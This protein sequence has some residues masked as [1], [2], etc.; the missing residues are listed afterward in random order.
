MTKIAVVTDST[1]YI[2]GELSNGF[3]IHTVP[4]QV[5]WGEETF[6][7]GI[8]M[9]PLEFYTR[10]QTAKLMPSTSQP[11]PAL[12]Q[13]VYQTLLDQE[14]EIISIHISQQLSGT[15][16]SAYQARE[17]LNTDRITIIDSKSTSMALGFP[18]LVLARAAKNG[19]TLEELTQIATNAVQNS[20]VL[21]A[22]STLEFL[23]RGGR[24]GGAQAFLGTALGLK[25]ILELRDGRIEPV[26]KVR[27]M[28]KAMDRLLE[29]LEQRIGN[30]RPIHLATLHANAPLEA[31]KLLEKACQR[32]NPGDIVE[33]FSTS[34]SPV[35]G[36]HTGPGTV[37][38]SYLVVIC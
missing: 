20:G 2:P 6:R 8:D 24:I 10:L 29:L 7:D 27:T 32:F 33:A 5:V 3:Q 14:Y 13:Q 9:Q 35:I 22:V 15:L 11:S 4:L 28:S 23:H 30:R 16:D 21:F 36:T 1:A 37:G 17:T 31:E 25:P 12:F 38:L 19:G 26:E 18:A 34:V